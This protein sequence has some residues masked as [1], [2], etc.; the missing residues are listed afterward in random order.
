MSEQNSKIKSP[1]EIF[2]NKKRARRDHLQLAIYE[3]PADYFSVTLADPHNAVLI[4][5]G[6]A[7]RD[8]YFIYGRFKSKELQMD[9]G[10]SQNQMGAP[11][12]NDFAA[13]TRLATFSLQPDSDDEDKPNE[14]FDRFAFCA[15]K[16]KPEAFE[17]AGLKFERLG[18][19]RL[20][21]DEL[22]NELDNFGL[23]WILGYELSS[24]EAQ[25]FLDR[26]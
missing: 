13:G 16:S 18:A 24:T 22:A 25:E 11:D 5:E 20:S 17:N 21:G 1:D 23:S 19:R 14:R 10:L 3:I 12:E 9:E 26:A 8:A 4:T 15:W 7:G 2:R 6:E